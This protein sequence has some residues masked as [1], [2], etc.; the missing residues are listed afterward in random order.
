M[1]ALAGSYALYEEYFE[2]CNY[3]FTAIALGDDGYIKSLSEAKSLL[4]FCS[5][6]HMKYLHT[7]MWIASFWKLKRNCFSMQMAHRNSIQAQGFRGS[8]IRRAR[9]VKGN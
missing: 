7:P 9:A 4:T 6:H 2:P 5:S 3:L 1:R 8:L